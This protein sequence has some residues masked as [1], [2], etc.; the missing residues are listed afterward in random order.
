[1]KRLLDFLR[2]HNTGGDVMVML[3]VII[4]VLSVYITLT[5]IGATHPVEKICPRATYVYILVDKQDV[6]IGRVT[7]NKY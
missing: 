2:K 7:K 6:E 4:V 5:A 3:I 1:M